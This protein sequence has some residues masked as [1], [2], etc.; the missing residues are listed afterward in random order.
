MD[1]VLKDFEK[2]QTDR[3]KYIKTLYL[4]MAFNI[5]KKSLF[6]TESLKYPVKL[7]LSGELIGILQKRDLASEIIKVF[8]DFFVCLLMHK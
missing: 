7:K 8:R 4:G 2:A 5:E 3:E 1:K 6:L